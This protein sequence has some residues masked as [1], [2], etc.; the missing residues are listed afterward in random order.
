MQFQVISFSQSFL[1]SDKGC[2]VRASLNC[3]NDRIS[4]LALSRPSDKILA[5]SFLVLV[6]RLNVVGCVIVFGV[7]GVG[8]LGEEDLICLWYCVVVV[9]ICLFEVCCLW[10]VGMFFSMLLIDFVEYCE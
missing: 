4:L 9:V 8:V 10:S 5:D 2:L 1:S 6:D 3:D 7:I